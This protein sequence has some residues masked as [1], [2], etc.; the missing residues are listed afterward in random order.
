LEALKYTVTL[1][2]TEDH[3]LLSKD[4]A[5]PMAEEGEEKD[6][7][8]DRH[9]L[10]GDR[11]DS[12]NLFKQEVQKHGE[13]YIKEDEN[14]ELIENTTESIVACYLRYPERSQS[15]KRKEQNGSFGRYSKEQDN[16]DI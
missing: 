1:L 6:K 10:E 13:L 3:P 8:R 7:D 12:W 15:W 14:I 9:E 4:E 2:P 11:I 5:R 16:G